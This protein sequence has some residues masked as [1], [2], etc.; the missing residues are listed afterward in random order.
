MT[1]MITNLHSTTNWLTRFS[2]ISL[3]ALLTSRAFGAA[4]AKPPN[5]LIFLADDMGFSDPGCYGGEISTPNLDALA[6]HGIRYT[7]FHNTARCSPTRAALLT[8]YYAQQVNFDAMPGV[9][10][11]DLRQRPAWA[12][13]LS[14][15]LR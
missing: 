11:S 2:A 4:P 13:V 6:A 5:F 15:Y 10:N 8:G 3:C 7:Q 9:K 14:E 1:V 12:H